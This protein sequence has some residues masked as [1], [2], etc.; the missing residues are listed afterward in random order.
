MVGSELGEAKPNQPVNGWLELDET[1]PTMKPET[2]P[3]R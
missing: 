1:K 2:K 3:N